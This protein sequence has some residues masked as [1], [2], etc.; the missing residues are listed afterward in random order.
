MPKGTLLPEE[1]AVLIDDGV[2]ARSIHKTLV[3]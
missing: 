3:Y 1:L 2:I